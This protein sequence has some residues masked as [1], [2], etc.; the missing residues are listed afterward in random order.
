MHQEVGRLTHLCNRGFAVPYRCK[1]SWN[2][3]Q[4][5]VCVCAYFV[6]FRVQG[7]LHLSK[8]RLFLNVSLRPPVS[9]A[10]QWFEK[11]G[12][13]GRRSY[14]ITEAEPRSCLLIKGPHEPG[15]TSEWL[16]LHSTCVTQPLVTC[17]W[18]ISLIQ[19]KTKSSAP[20]MTKKPLH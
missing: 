5:S 8:G 16:F 2:C 20:E 9:E 3:A 4:K 13:P 19:L 11:A 18:K 15:P 1:S 12:G 14:R 7:F 17:F 6:T 10:L